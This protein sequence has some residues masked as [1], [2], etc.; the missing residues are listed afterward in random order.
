MTKL[1]TIFLKPFNTWNANAMMATF[2]APAT[3]PVAASGPPQLPAKLASLDTTWRI[4]NAKHAP[5][6][7]S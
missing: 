3:M 7:A 1:E 2:Q 6:A 4:M 5:V